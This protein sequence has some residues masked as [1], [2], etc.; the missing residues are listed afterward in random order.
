MSKNQ[1]DA[2]PLNQHDVAPFWGNAAAPMV[3]PGR[4]PA[5]E[6][7]IAERSPM[8]GR[9]TELRQLCDYHRI[10]A[11]GK[12]GVCLIRG[13]A[14]MGKSLLV[15][16]FGWQL[17][18]SGHVM[19]A[20][21]CA[22]RV[23]VQPY[24]AFSDLLDAYLAWLPQCDGQV[25]ERQKAKLT[26]AVGDMAE[27]VIRFNRGMAHLLAVEATLP[28]LEPDREQRRFQRALTQLFAAMP[29]GGAPMVLLVEDIQ[30]MD[31]SGLLLLALLSGE[32]GG[33]GLMLL[34]TLREGE[35]PSPSLAAYLRALEES[36]F[37]ALNIRLR[38][39]DPATMEAFVSS[40]L[41]LSPA[42]AGSLAWRVQEASMGNPYYAVSL[43]QT[44]VE[45]QALVMDGDNWREDPQRMRR[46]STPPNLVALLVHRMQQLTASDVSLLGAAAVIGRE[47]SLPLLA[48]LVAL[49]AEWV[50]GELDQSIRRHLVHLVT[51]RQTEPA[52]NMLAFT[53]ER[54]REAALNRLPPDGQRRLHARLVALLAV[55]EAEDSD[56]LLFRIANHAVSAG[57]ADG[58]RRYVPPAAERAWALHA[59]AEALR[60]CGAVVPVLSPDSEELKTWLR[61]KR[62]MAALHQLAGHYDEVVALCDETIPYGADNL[63]QADILRVKGMA[64]F[65]A[66][67][68]VEAEEALRA[69]L[70]LL[71]ERLPKTRVAALLQ[72][73][74]EW[75]AVLVGPVR[76]QHKREAEIQGILQLYEPLG[77]KYILDDLI[78][79]MHMSLRMLHLGAR[80]LGPSA[81]TG[82]CLSGYGSLLMALPLP[83]AAY[84]THER[85]I[86]MRRAAAD[87]WGEAQG[88]Q[89]MGYGLTW[90]GRNRE[91]L[92]PF[93]QALAIYGRIGDEWEQ[94]ICWNGLTNGHLRLCQYEKAME[95][96][97]HYLDISER[98]GDTY[99]ICT[100]L[101][102]LCLA[103]H[104]SGALEAAEAH[105]RRALALARENGLHL[106]NC[107]SAIH[108]GCA[109]MHAGR[110]Q[111]AVP[112]LEEACAL[113]ARHP[114]IKEFSCHAHT[115]LAEARFEAW[116]LEAEPGTRPSGHAADSRLAA[117]RKIS[118]KALRNTRAWPNRRGDAERVHALIAGFQGKT[119]EAARYFKR[120][121]MHQAQAERVYPMAQTH[122]DLARVLCVRGKDGWERQL[123][124]AARLF[125]SVG[126]EAD[127]QGCERTDAG[128]VS[129]PRQ[130]TRP[131][132]R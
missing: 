89:L 98:T 44:M 68:F 21:Q 74:G 54:V 23:G 81:E 131:S 100:A 16:T 117:L 53:H 116:L 63:E 33:T 51:G 29:L 45:E 39:F 4:E 67:K 101:A 108:L 59:N 86:A 6:T 113:V 49:P 14:G 48:R 18:Q 9:D 73:M 84:R 37:P 120:S 5:S 61:L 77:W 69:G 43:L 128:T 26:R 96:A 83:G 105:G 76:R 111:E 103:S 118:V 95:A 24:G 55:A 57:D 123:Q 130:T 36:R 42:K 22:Q 79:Y 90:S 91:S 2:P 40:L 102:N 28:A 66:G 64:L 31:E 13:E 109:L 58:L 88:L 87:P 92:S 110:P 75:A 25:I 65:R 12:G 112:L 52:H 129:F 121:L 27:D 124:E 8:M 106:A 1:H 17:A 10:I 3:L 56:Q 35:T 34:L 82:R 127:A 132:S 62:L 126:A 11:R 32:I 71:G 78:R 20:A 38:P 114:F 99:G 15:E 80:W 19:L 107:F 122:R 60:L 85:A 70:A 94:G 97:Q 47:F 93:S 125:R 50:M 46:L 104:Q 115:H 72:A 119:R 30:W 41:R 7:D